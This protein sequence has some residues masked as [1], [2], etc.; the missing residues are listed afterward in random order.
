MHEDDRIA[1]LEQ[2]LERIEDKMDALT[3]AFEQGRG[4]VKLL[5]WL[6]AAVTT[7]GSVFAFVRTYFD[8]TVR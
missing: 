3:S 8:I 6:A 1:A 5:G 4:A 7:L 2:R